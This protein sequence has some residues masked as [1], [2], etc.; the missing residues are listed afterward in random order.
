MIPAAATPMPTIIAVIGS[1]TPGGGGAPKPEAGEMSSRL[2]RLFETA[3]S[4]PPA[5]V[6]WPTIAEFD[7]AKKR[8]PAPSDTI[9]S[10]PLPTLEVLMQ[11]EPARV[12]VSKL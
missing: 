11:A 10:L 5:M 2:P 1:G 6:Y 8:W 4:V 3:T 7:A 12:V 9:P